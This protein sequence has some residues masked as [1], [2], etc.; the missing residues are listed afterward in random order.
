MQSVCNK[1]KQ[2][3]PHLGDSW[4]LSCSAVEALTAELKQGWG[5]SGTRAL[6]D[7][8][9]ATAVRHVRALRRLGLG[10]GALRASGASG[11]G[12]TRA[13]DRATD[14]GAVDRHSPEP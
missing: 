3:P 4:C 8:L 13:T 9:L 6:C 12:A 2:S 10:A 5:L 14:V 11:A 7:D 1:C